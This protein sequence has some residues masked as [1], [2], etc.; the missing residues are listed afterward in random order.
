MRAHTHTHT[1]H[2]PFTTH[3]LYK[4]D[5]HVYTPHAHTLPY[6][7]THLHEGLS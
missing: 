3:T 1:T 7:Q 5:T 4:P 6:T 2:E